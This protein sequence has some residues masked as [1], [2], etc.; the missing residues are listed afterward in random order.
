MKR[1]SSKT[2]T[3]LI[4]IILLAV[5]SGFL[6]SYYNFYLSDKITSS[7][8]SAKDKNHES[9]SIIVKSIEGKSFD[10]AL[11]LIKMYVD[12]NGGYIIL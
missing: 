3:L 12:N 2:I 11:D 5:N 6:F 7:M 1:W 4:V 9:I 10:E 8:V